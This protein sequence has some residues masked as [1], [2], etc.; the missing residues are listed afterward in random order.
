MDVVI[1]CQY[2]GYKTVKVI[3]NQKSLEDE[4]CSKC[5]DRNLVI[6]EL[7]KT[8]IDSY[9]GSPAFPEKDKSDNCNPDAGWPWNTGGD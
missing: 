2:C 7:S 4:I 1:N 8:K 3:Y 6:K 5:G 9:A